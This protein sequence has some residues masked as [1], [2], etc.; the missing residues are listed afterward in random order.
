M[1]T[2]EQAK[3]TDE[4]TVEVKTEADETTSVVD[5]TNDEDLSKPDAV[6]AI[7]AD[8]LAQELNEI[9][10]TKDDEIRALTEKAL[11]AQAELQNAQRRAEKDVASAHKYALERFVNDLLP[12]IDSLEQA[13]AVN[14]DDYADAEANPLK[15]GVA[16]TLKMMLDVVAKYGVKQLDPAGEPFD[17]AQHEAMAMQEDANVEPNTVLVVYQKGYSLNDRLVRPARV[18]VSKATEASPK[19]DEQA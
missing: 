17:P 1:A 13:L 2:E 10:S 18:V 3:P 7:S 8:T 6:D 15:E 5:V 19:I 12:V 16:L 14:S 4:S 9:I 11:R